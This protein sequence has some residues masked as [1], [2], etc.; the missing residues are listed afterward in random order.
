[1]IHKSNLA[2]SIANSMS[3]AKR[4]ERNAIR[5]ITTARLLLPPAPECLIQLNERQTLV[6]LG[7]YEIEL[8]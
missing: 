8:C 1:M 2:R 4:I 7:L 6:E 5:F 3:A